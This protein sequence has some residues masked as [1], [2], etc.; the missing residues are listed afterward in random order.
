MPGLSG[1]MSAVTIPIGSSAA[2]SVRIWEICT[3]FPCQCGEWNSNPV[4]AMRYQR[5]RSPVFMVGIGP[6]PY[7]K[8][9][10]RVRWYLMARSEEHTSELQSPVHLVCRLL[11]EKKNNR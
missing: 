6:L 7:M 5:T 4:A 8:T 2:T 9:G 3:V 10:D 11:L 1:T